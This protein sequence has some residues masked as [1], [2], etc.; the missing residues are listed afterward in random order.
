MLLV[1]AD[2]V[3]QVADPSLDLARLPGRIETHHAGLAVGRLGQAEQHQ[4]RRRL[5]GAVLAE[6][7]EDLARVDLEV[8]LVDRRQRRRIS[9]SAGGSG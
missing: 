4:D 2:R 7:A 9:W 8:E 6:Q 1:E 3:G 5:A